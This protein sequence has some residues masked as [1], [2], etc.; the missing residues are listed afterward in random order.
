MCKVHK[1][2]FNCNSNCNSIRTSEDN[3]NIFSEAVSMDQII[4]ECFSTTQLQKGF[5]RIKKLNDIKCM[6]LLNTNS[7]RNYDILFRLSLSAV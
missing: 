3:I 6:T 4:A 2:L 5:L 1:N 7:S